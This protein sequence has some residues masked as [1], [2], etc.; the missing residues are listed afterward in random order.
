MGELDSRGKS[1]CGLAVSGPVPMPQWSI[2]L[3]SFGVWRCKFTGSVIVTN[4][5]HLILFTSVKYFC[6]FIGVKLTSL[7]LLAHNCRILTLQRLEMLMGSYAYVLQWC[8]IFLSWHWGCLQC[9]NSHFVICGVLVV[10]CQEKLHNTG[11]F[12][13]CVG[14]IY[15]LHCG[16]VVSGCYWSPWAE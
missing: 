8:W 12:V 1:N 16:W 15:L 2:Y 3:P 4:E 6:I 9:L 14:K 10:A 13:V 5:Q 11:T 7:P